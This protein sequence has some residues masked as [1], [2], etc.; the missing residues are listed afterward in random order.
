MPASGFSRIGLLVV[1]S[2]RL[3][4]EYHKNP[5][6]YNYSHADSVIAIEFLEMIIVGHAYDDVLLMIKPCEYT[7]SRLINYMQ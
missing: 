1:T 5:H 6:R 4:S 3:L 7:P 2:D